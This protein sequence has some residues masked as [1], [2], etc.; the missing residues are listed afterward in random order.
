M[1]RWWWWRWLLNRCPLRLVTE[2]E[3]RLCLSRLRLRLCSRSKTRA[4][5]DGDPTW[6][7]LQIR[8]NR[9]DDWIKRVI[10]LQRDRQ[11]SQDHCCYLLDKRERDDNCLQFHP[12]PAAGKIVFPVMLNNLLLWKCTVCNGSIFFQHPKEKKTRVEALTYRLK[13]IRQP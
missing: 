8:K 13:L 11:E 12:A 5:G 6:T 1:S 3:W 9:R 7:P 10:Q 4:A 2:L